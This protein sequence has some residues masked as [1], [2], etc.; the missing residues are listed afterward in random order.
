MW[1]IYC[2]G[3]LTSKYS[4]PLLE[5]FYDLLLNII[6]P[7]NRDCHSSVISDFQSISSTKK[8]ENIINYKIR[9]IGK[10]WIL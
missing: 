2:L 10:Q 3:V 1:N 6:A 7:E 5:T 9:N 4:W 8:I